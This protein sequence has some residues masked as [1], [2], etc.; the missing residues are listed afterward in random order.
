MSK[1]KKIL[2][3]FITIIL[4]GIYVGVMSYIV[5]QMRT[6]IIT[7]PLAFGDYIVT[8]ANGEID[9]VDE[10]NT[11]YNNI[12][13]ELLYNSNAE[14]NNLKLIHLYGIF[15]DET[16]NNPSLSATIVLE[17]T[18]VIANDESLKIIYVDDNKSI[19]FVDKDIEKRSRE[20]SNGDSE[21]YYVVVFDVENEGHYGLVSQ[22]GEAT[23]AFEVFILSIVGAIVLF[24]VLFILIKSKNTVKPLTGTMDEIP[25]QP[26]NI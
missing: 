13:A 1:Q 26:N 5:E 25:T 15:S 12:N 9:P 23:F 16:I 19:S 7:D 14:L 4:T 8:D 11:L 3:I 18:R 24:F 2:F 20:N 22:T 10:N 17:T 21:E 6:P